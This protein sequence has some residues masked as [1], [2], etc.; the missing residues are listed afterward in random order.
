MACPR[1]THLHPAL[2]STAPI[3]ISTQPPSL[4]YC[5]DCMG[6]GPR[7]CAHRSIPK[8]HVHAH[9]M[10]LALAPHVQSQ[11]LA[12][13]ITYYSGIA[14]ADTRSQDGTNTGL[15]IGLV[16]MHMHMRRR[17]MPTCTCPHAHT[18]TRPCPRAHAHMPTCAHVHTIVPTC[19]HPTCT[20]EC[21]HTCTH[22]HMYTCT[23]VHLCT[24]SRMYTCMRKRRAHRRS[25]ASTFCASSACVVALLFA[26]AVG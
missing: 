12:T 20:C 26:C 19:P 5:C 16:S 13:R 7:I 24:H 18:P 14:Y 23:H 11:W 25:A 15:I 21:M 22:A 1:L 4:I 2:V 9:E 8:A 10:L 17:C 6:Y 3:S